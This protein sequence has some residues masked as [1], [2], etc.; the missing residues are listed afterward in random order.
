MS[1]T[2]GYGSLNHPLEQL[3]P[4]LVPAFIP[5]PVVVL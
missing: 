1:V 2:V 3:R 4:L 5:D